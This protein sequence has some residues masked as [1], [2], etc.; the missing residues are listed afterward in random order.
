MDDF[1][2]ALALLLEAGEHMN[3]YHIGNPEEVTI[4]DLAHRVA[5]IFGREVTFNHTE[6]FAGETTRRSRHRKDRGAGIC[7]A[8]SLDEGLVSTLSWYVENLALRGQR[9]AVA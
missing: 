7:A 5:A 2:N 1:T 4:A 9:M 3:I 8:G 6:A